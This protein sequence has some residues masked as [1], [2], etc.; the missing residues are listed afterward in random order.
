MGTFSQFD[1]LQEHLERMWERL[2]GG[3]PGQPR[4]LPP[5]FEPPTDVYQTADAVVVV[6]EISGMRGRDVE[7][8]IADGRLTVRGEKRDPHGHGER[9]YS[10]MEIGC[11]PFART[12]TLPA[13]VE[14][15]RATLRYEDGLLEITLPK[16]QPT[17]AHR[18]RVTVRGA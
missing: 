9:V 15:E 10:Q 1:H 11:G 12:I 4:F 16:R 5:V 7:V 3:S 2:T 18:I 13:P 17:A 8:S 14:G 6:L